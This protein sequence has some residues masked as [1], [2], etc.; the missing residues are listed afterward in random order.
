MRN[1]DLNMETVLSPAFMRIWDNSLMGVM[2]IDRKGI[3]RYMNRLLIRT[4]DLQDE[5][6]LGQKMVDFYPL[7]SDCHISIQ[8]LE[9]GA[10]T[11]KKTIV[12][13]TRKKKL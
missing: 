4:D 12:Y 10:P 8:T 7:E 11:I 9:T 2:I 6:I 13:Y 5:D 1:R 3:V